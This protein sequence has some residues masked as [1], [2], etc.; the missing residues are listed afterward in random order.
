MIFS[1]FEFLLFFAAVLALR[2]LMPDLA[3]EK[4]FLLV[5]SWLFYMSWGPRFV[6]LIVFTSLVDWWIGRR[7]GETEDSR[8]RRRLLV[9]SLTL[10]LWRQFGKHFPERRSSMRCHSFSGSSFSVRPALCSANA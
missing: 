1:S 5:A 3:W 7:L 9:T 8:L 4:R 2:A 6:L 10:N